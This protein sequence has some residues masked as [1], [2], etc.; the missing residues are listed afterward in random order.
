MNTATMKSRVTGFF[1]KIILAAFLLLTILYFLAAFEYRASFPYGTKINGVYCAGL[2]VQ[3]VSS[4]LDATAEVSP[5]RILFPGDRVYEIEPSAVNLKF[6]Y[7][8]ELTRLNYGRN[9]FLWGKNLFSKSA[10]ETITPSITCDKDML[11]SAVYELSIFKEFDEEKEPIV[12]IVKI[13]G[14]Y[15]LVDTTGPTISKEA[16]FDYICEELDRGNL[17]ISIPDQYVKE[18]TYSSLEKSVLEQWK[19]VEGFVTPKITYDMGDEKI[20]VDPAFL[21]SILVKENGSF[22]KES[23]GSLSFDEQAVIGFADEICD[24]YETAD[25][26]RTFTDYNG[27]VKTLERNYF[28]TL[29]DKK[30]EEEYLLNAIKSGVKENHIPKYIKEPYH[31]GLDDIGP[32]HIEIDLTRQKLYFIKGGKL[33]LETDVVTGN[34]NTLHATNEMATFIRKK[35]TDTYLR[36]EGYR[37]F[38]KYWMAVYQNVIGIHD[39]SWQKAFGGNRYLTYGSK[40]CINVPEEAA[41]T[42]YDEVELDMPVLI[43]K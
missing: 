24:R 29:I 22:K 31:R 16:V 1:V 10:E 42:L 40:G 20:E 8:Y 23:D 37:S 13:D 35:S 12:D 43:Y 6:N 2:G 4:I 11:R 41:K 9:P 15:T 3:E 28:G 14:A 33:F 32:D 27:E 38:V 34:P 30:A 7:E 19:S 18:Y 21:S 39:A 17:E 26:P 25:K 5:V 36:G